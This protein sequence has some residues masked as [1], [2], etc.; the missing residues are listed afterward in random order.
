MPST[1]PALIARRLTTDAACAAHLRRLLATR[2]R[3]SGGRVICLGLSELDRLRAAGAAVGAE[4]CAAVADAA[5]KWR[6]RTAALSVLR[7]MAAHGVPRSAA[8]VSSVLRASEDVGELHASLEELG[9]CLGGGGGGGGGGGSS[10][11][12]RIKFTGGVTLANDDVKTLAAELLVREAYVEKSRVR[13]EGACE[14]RDGDADGDGDGDGALRAAGALSDAEALIRSI[15]DERRSALA[16]QLLVEA[17]PSLQAAEAAFDEILAARSRRGWR[18]PAAAASLHRRLYNALLR[19][20]AVEGA[21]AKAE[22]V[23]LLMEHGEVPVGRVAYTRVMLAH[24]REAER[25]AE[26]EGEA[27]AAKDAVGAV[28]AVLRRKAEAAARCGGG[29]DDGVD[30]V[31]ELDYAVL[32]RACAAA[33]DVAMAEAAL[34]ALEAGGGCTE[35]LAYDSLLRVYAVKAREIGAGVEE[36]GGGRREK[37]RLLAR[38]RALMRLMGSRGMRVGWAVEASLRALCALLAADAAELLAVHRTAV[39]GR[40]EHRSEL[41]ET[42]PL[43]P[44]KKPQR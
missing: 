19:H 7:Y 34:E 29:G 18:Q 43:F 30:A 15:A 4:S 5:A 25:A 32:M 44:P 22:A 31:N 24:I 6:S 37:E 36:E 2:D 23:L 8:V 11:S 14:G 1:S 27:V 12:N 39:E 38:T 42:L 35:T 13:L 41:M 21:G 33:G 17:Q 3:R 16:C 28:S 40:S 26:E 20:C 10:S 9:G